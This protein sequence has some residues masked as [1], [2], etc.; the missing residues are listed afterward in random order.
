MILKIQ[1]LTDLEQAQSLSPEER[2]LTVRNYLDYI[3]DDL[4]TENSIYLPVN[5]VTPSEN[6]G[7]TLQ[8]ERRLRVYGCELI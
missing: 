4:E 6:D 1:Q 5:T 2:V 3:C 7:I 8:N